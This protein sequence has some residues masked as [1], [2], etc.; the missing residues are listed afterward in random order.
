MILSGRRFSPERSAGVHV[1]MRVLVV[2]PN[3]LSD[4]LLAGLRSE[5][6]VC[7]TTRDL[8]DL[9]SAI[10]LSGP[11]DLVVVDV[12]SPDPAVL[13]ALRALRR[14]GSAHPVLVVCARLEPREEEASLHAGADDVLRHPL[15]LPVFHARIQALVRRAR[16][17]ASARLA[18]G[19]VTLDQELHAVLVDGRRVPLTGREYDFLQVM[20]LHKGVLLTKERFLSGLYADA[21][22]APDLKI[23]DVFVCKLRRKLAACGA[24]EMIRTVWGRGHVLFDPSP[25]AVAAARA[26]HRPETAPEPAP[27]GW[28]RRVEAT[29][30][31][32]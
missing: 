13:R 15:S 4:R 6:V 11:Y 2:S 27:R 28:E 19:N 20:M 3:A 21:E 17:Y 22:E 1:L 25:A 31:S 29:R 12:F 26:A 14:S 8:D 5:G 10:A 9:P 16:G 30:L 24:A 23:V 18:C 7:D 32:A